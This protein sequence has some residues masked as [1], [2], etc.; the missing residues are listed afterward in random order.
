MQV[1]YTA[2]KEVYVLF[3]E[4]WRSMKMRF[5]NWVVLIEDKE[6]DVYM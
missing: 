4:G 3:V 5:L 2:N 1:C 6:A